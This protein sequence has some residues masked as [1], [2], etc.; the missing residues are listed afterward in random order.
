MLWA[1]RLGVTGHAARMCSR[2]PFVCCGPQ[3]TTRLLCAHKVGLQRMRLSD[4]NGLAI[5]HGL[6]LYECHVW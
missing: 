1:T 4:G 3:I 6:S 5:D 2:F